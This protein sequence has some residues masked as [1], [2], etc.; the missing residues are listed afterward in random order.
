[1]SDFPV[2]DGPVVD[3]HQHFWDP[4]A[5]RHPW[6][7]RH[8]NIPFRY[9]DY[10][11]IKRPYLPPDYQADAAG[12]RV[13][14]T[15]YI[16]AEW[17]PDHPAEET[18]YVA[19]LTAAFGLPSA[20]VAQAWLDR[21]DAAHVLAAQAGFP[22]VRGVRHKPGGPASPTE[23][24]AART[25]MSD[26]AWRRGYALLERHG[27]HFDLQ[28]PWWNLPEAERL[29][30]DFPATTIILNHAGLPADRSETGLRAWHDAMGRFAECPNVR[31]KI[32]GLGQ[33]GHAWTAQA[34][35]WIV[36]EAIAMFGARRC[37]FASNFPVDSLCASFDTIY[38]GFKRIV[39]SM[40]AEDQ[41]AL[42]C[43]TARATYRT[44]GATR[45]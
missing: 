13:V 37:M 43:D 18:R 6:L 29:A 4:V 35:G 40:S 45:R 30:R 38:S 10:A 20:V 12:H 36:R 11:A 34:N 39:A 2:Y 27:L 23:V 8:E 25:L 28:T 9:G 22:L 21:D 44:D 32:S 19:G 41:R 33:P 5:N 3:A 17:D 7:S 42:F 16:E 14:E 31:V 1:V 15:V 26:D 24:G